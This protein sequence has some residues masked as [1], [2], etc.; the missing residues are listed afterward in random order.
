MSYTG[1]TGWGRGAWNDGPWDSPT[2]VVVTQSGATSALGSVTIAGASTL[3]LTGTSATS[4]LG[5]STVAIS[6]SVAVTG[7]TATGFTGEENVWGRVVPN[8]TTTYSTIT[9]SQT[10]NWSGIAA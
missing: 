10:P 6:I 3:T 5:T 7:V 1:L 2:P 4:S 8:Q 9:V